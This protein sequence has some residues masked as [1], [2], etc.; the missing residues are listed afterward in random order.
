MELEWA[1]EEYTVY[2]TRNERSRLAR[3]KTGIWKVRGMR[4]NLRKVD[5]L[6][7]VRMKILYVYY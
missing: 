1:A 7:V 2:C 5:A 3:F 6:Y 4:K